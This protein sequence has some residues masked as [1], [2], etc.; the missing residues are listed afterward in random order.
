MNVE[1]QIENETHNIANFL[2][3]TAMK[4]NRV[5]HMMNN[6]RAARFSAP[7]M[8]SRSHLLT[9]ICQL[10][11]RIKVMDVDASLF[12]R[13][14]RDEDIESGARVSVDTC[15]MRPQR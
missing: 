6:A 15:R 3:T 2:E 5:K 4:G 9:V 8:S 12:A 11:I 13:H 1:R 14:A 10:R 7:K